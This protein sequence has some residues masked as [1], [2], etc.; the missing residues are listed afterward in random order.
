MKI[1]RAPLRERAHRLIG[2]QSVEFDGFREAEPPAGLVSLRR[3]ER[4]NIDPTST[5]I[6]FNLRVEDR[7]LSQPIDELRI[8]RRGVGRSDRS[9][10][11][12]ENLLER[13]VIALAVAARQ[14]GERAR[15]RL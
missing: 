1:E 4:R 15:C 2:W 3:F 9:V 8:L 11:P 6:A 5:P 7:Q 13:V 14:I 12:P 10:E